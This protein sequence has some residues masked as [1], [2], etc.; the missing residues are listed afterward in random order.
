MK[1]IN[2][3]SFLGKITAGAGAALGLSQLPSELLAHARMLNI[4][5]GFQTYPIRDILAK[6][7]SGTLKMM[8]MQGYQLTEMCSPKGYIDAGYG[9]LVGMKASDMRK[10]I[11]DAGL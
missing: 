1:T 6:D 5:I 9:P 4:P 10:I 8:A 11:T 2:R 7:F 3:R